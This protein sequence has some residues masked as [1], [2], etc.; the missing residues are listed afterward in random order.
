MSQYIKTVFIYSGPIEYFVLASGGMSKK[1][2]EKY[3]NMKDLKMKYR[4]SKSNLI[5]LCI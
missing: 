1:C 5:Y 3:L 4:F 2:L